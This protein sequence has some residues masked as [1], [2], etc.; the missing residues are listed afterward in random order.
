[1]D[2]FEQRIAEAVNEK[3]NDGTVEKLIEQYI[4]KAVSQSLNGIFGYSGSGRKMI[5]SKLD[6]VMVPV[7]ENHDFNKY[8]V[9]LD[10]VLTEIINNTNLKDNKNILDNFSELMKEPEMKEI[11]LSD[12]FKKYCEHVAKNVD[13]DELEACCEDGEP[14]YEHVTANM[15]VEYVDKGWFKSS[16][17]D[18]FVNFSCEE[19]ERL[20]FQ[21]K[22]YKRQESNLWDILLID[23]E[24]V[25]VTSLRRLSDF[26]VF[27]IVL[28]RGFVKI[29][30]DTENECDDDIE[31]DDKPEWSLD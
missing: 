24:H 10:N 3:L 7:I 9:K 19:D 26:E 1:M 8:I 22:L 14:Y 4:E 5:Q 23:T 15:E 12:I 25:D 18:C 28:K 20:N 6:E 13:T 2:G 29:A 31:P 27:L 16:Y 21:I 17:D 30:I 11:K